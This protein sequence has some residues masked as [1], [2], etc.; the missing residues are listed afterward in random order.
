MKKFLFLR[1]FAICNTFSNNTR[2]KE[3]YKFKIFKFFF[4]LPKWIKWF[5]TWCRENSN[6][7]SFSSLLLDFRPC[8]KLKSNILK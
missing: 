2:Q 4:G 3:N 8:S 7:L 5:L 6:F 1:N